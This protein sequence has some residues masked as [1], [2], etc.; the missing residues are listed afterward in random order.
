LYDLRVS[1]SVFLDSTC[2]LFI[3]VSVKVELIKH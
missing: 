3:D 2:G 1:L